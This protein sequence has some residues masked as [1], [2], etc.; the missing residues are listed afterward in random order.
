MLRRGSSK[1]Q[2]IASLTLSQ[3]R[4]LK[5]MHKNKRKLIGPPKIPNKLGNIRW[6]PHNV[7]YK[8]ELEKLELLTH[9]YT[10]HPSEY[11]P[12]TLFNKN[13]NIW[14]R[15]FPNGKAMRQIEWQEDY[16]EDCVYTRK[17]KRPDMQMLEDFHNDEDVFDEYSRTRV[18]WWAEDRIIVL[19]NMSQRFQGYTLE[20]Q[21]SLL[22]NQDFKEL[23]TDLYEDVQIR[24]V[25]PQYACKILS[26]MA[27]F[28]MGKSKIMERLYKK[29]HPVVGS[30][31]KEDVLEFLYAIRKLQHQ[32][33]LSLLP[34]VF[35]VA[36]HF[37][38]QFTTEELCDIAETIALSS[39]WSELSSSPENVKKTSASSS[40]WKKD[41]ID[42]ICDR[43][44]TLFFVP[45]SDYQRT[46]ISS[47]L[48]SLGSKCPESHLAL[49]A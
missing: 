38:R 32:V 28:G 13:P 44:R 39:S 27:N 29:T 46:R 33:D 8:D 31:S 48:A 41:V 45:M 43:L 36:W 17:Y 25:Y 14:A 10:L 47:A 21:R 42:G 18:A 12:T 24:R 3:K 20:D 40:A 9:N 30:S 37:R 26:A 7:L 22:D 2:R 15:K 35:K 19:Y 5:R 4:T 23:F 11:R 16:G 34:K 1:L 6:V 49:S